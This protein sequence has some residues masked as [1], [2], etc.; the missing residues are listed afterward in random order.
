MV[1]ITDLFPFEVNDNPVFA[2]ALPRKH[3]GAPRPNRRK[4]DDYMQTGIRGNPGSPPPLLDAARAPQTDNWIVLDTNVLLDLWLFCNPSTAWVAEAL[5]EG[6]LQ[7]LATEAMLE[8][9]KWVADRAF[10]ARYVRNPSFLAAP[11]RI[12]PASAPCLELRCRDASDQ[13]FV[14]LAK[15]AQAPLWTRDRDLLAL[16][17]RAAHMGVLIETPE[18]AR[19]RL[20][21]TPDVGR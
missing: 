18:Q 4:A 15:A 21:P 16:R 2:S 12:V 19:L 1:G 14:D 20:H 10:P 13:M 11:A 17:R 8:E 3:A 7:W 6:S 9:L 5:Q